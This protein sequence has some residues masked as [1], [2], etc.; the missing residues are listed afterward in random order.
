[1]LLLPFPFLLSYFRFHQSCFVF[2]LHVGRWVLCYRQAFALTQAK[3]F[4]VPSPWMRYPL[5]EQ[6][7]CEV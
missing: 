5:L 2:V 7:T 3:Y 4:G 6:L 1:M